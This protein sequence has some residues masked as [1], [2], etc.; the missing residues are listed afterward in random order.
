MNSRPRARCSVSFPEMEQVRL[1]LEWRLVANHPL[2]GRVRALRARAPAAARAAGPRAPRR[3]RTGCSHGADVAAGRRGGIAAAPARPRGATARGPCAGSSSASRAS[4]RAHPSR[5]FRAA[6]RPRLSPQVG[7]WDGRHLEQLGAGRAAA[8]AA[9]RRARAPPADDAA[10]WGAD[11]WGG[12][13]FELDA[14]AR[15]SARP[16]RRPRRCVCA[17]VGFPP[18]GRRRRRRRRDGAG[19]PLASSSTRRPAGRRAAAGAGGG[20]RPRRAAGGD[21]PAALEA[22]ASIDDGPATVGG[23]RLAPPAA[24]VVVEFNHDSTIVCA[25]DPAS[26]DSRTPRSPTFL[27]PKPRTPHRRPRAAPRSLA[28]GARRAR[29]ARLVFAALRASRRDRG[30]GAPGRLRPLSPSS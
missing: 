7:A 28:T 11:D 25:V 20:V 9:R 22:S 2:D 10:A 17:R 1:P 19:T 23:L 21:A 15:P 8:A 30:R 13:L 18:P 5:L 24:L 6:A 26:P 3:R 27:H 12:V 29:A 14:G 16:P 4:A